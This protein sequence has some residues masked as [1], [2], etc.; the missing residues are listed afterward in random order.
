MICLAGPRALVLTAACL[1][2]APAGAALLA[3]THAV[4]R[5]APD[6]FADLA[7]SLLPAVVNISSSETVTGDAPDGDDDSGPD[8]SPAPPGS[9]FEKFFHDFMNRQHGQNGGDGGDDAPRKMQSLGSGFI[10]DPSGLIVTNNHVIAGA[11]E[12]TVTLQDNTVMKATLVG[13]DDRT[14]LALLRVHPDKPLPAVAFGDSD[15]SRVGDW[16]LAIGN[17]FGLGGTVTAGIVSA[18]GRDIQQGPYDDFIQTDAPINRGNSGGPLF[19]M[20]GRVVG[21][22]TAIYSPS[23]GSIGIGFSIPS[24]EAKLVVDQLHAYGH[25]RR[26]W[27]G[28]RVQAMTPDIAESLN[29]KPADGALVAGVDQHGPAANA[30]LRNGDVILSFNGEPVHEMRTLPRVVAETGIDQRVPVVVW[31]DGRK[32]TVMLVVAELPDDQA[33]KPA[34]VKQAPPKPK[35]AGGVSIGGLGLSLAPVDDALRQKYQIPDNQKG[36]VVVSV[37]KSGVAADRGIKP[38]NILIEVQQDDATSPDQVADLIAKAE[39]GRRADILFLVQDQDGTR[40]IPMPLTR[41]RTTN[42][43][44]DQPAKAAIPASQTATSS[45]VLPPEQPIAPTTAPSCTIRTPPLIRVRSRKAT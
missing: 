18:R 27:I 35:P 14:D 38:G 39:Q 1:A 5:G 19:D 24:N 36:L 16:V 12:I 4:A 31:R 11:D 41:A 28:V 3:P 44:L 6:S 23:G 9:P 43:P 26:G 33:S 30:K 37:D 15:K 22:N 32:Q 8:Q 17:P 34:P 20:G 25:T 7:A 42:R 2:M 10:V 40:W 21:I 13:H 29:L 45:S